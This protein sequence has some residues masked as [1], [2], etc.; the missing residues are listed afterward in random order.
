MRECVEVVDRAANA[1]SA[2]WILVR[3]DFVD[4]GSKINHADRYYVYWEE[5]NVIL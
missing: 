1:R 5:D 4:V 3:R 2:F